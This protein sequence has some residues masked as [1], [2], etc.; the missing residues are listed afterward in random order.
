MSDKKSHSIRNFFIFLFAI[1]L[2]AYIFSK[3]EVFEK[4]PSPPSLLSE[5]R[6]IDTCSRAL[7]NNDAIMAR[8]RGG[9]LGDRLVYSTYWGKDATKAFMVII[10]YKLKSDFSFRNHTCYVWQLKSDMSIMYRVE[11]DGLR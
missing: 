10:K 6:A 1:Y 8:Y 3:F 5:D 11:N 2:I 4:K 7:M 9:K